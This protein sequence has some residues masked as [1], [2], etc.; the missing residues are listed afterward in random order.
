MSRKRGRDRPCVSCK[1]LEQAFCRARIGDDDYASFIANC[2]SKRCTVREVDASV[3]DDFLK[4]IAALADDPGRPVV[5]TPGGA[6]DCPSLSCRIT[7]SPLMALRRGFSCGQSGITRITPRYDELEGCSSLGQV[8]GV[9]D[10]LGRR[11]LAEGL[12][13]RPLRV[14]YS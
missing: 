5:D 11:P 4:F 13:V 1:C 10:N 2:T 12:D 7:A 9:L 6:T 14:S 3:V 8:R